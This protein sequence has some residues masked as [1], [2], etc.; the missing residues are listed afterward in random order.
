MKAQ[1]QNPQR[2][3]RTED[4]VGSCLRLYANARAQSEVLAHSTC[5]ARMTCS[6]V[7]GNSILF[8]SLGGP[9]PGLTSGP[10]WNNVEARR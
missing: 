7:S 8:E 10:T 3:E 5:K 4:R 9:S 6:E 1:R 2:P